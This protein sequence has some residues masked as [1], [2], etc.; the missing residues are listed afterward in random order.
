MALEER[1]EEWQHWAARYRMQLDNLAWHVLVR[2]SIVFTPAIWPRS[3]RAECR[4][5]LQS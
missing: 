5:R 4:F 3:P 1:E 2:T